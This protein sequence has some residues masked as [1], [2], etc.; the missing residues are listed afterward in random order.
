MTRRGFTVVNVLAWGTL[1]LAAIIIVVSAYWL[2][3]PYKPITVHSATV[4]QKTVKQGGT[5]LLKL[6]YTKRNP[7]P[8]VGTRSFVDGLVYATPPVKGNVMVGTFTLVRAIPV[9]K[10]LPP[11]TYRL[12]TVLRYEMNPIRVVGYSYTSDS[13]TVVAVP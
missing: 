3:Y 1:L 6:D 13:F 5:L 11:G 4:M 7:V 12:H 8:G 9:P 2:L 10:E